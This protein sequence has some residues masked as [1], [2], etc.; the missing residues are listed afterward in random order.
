MSNYVQTTFFAPK[1]A[2]LSGNP[3]KIIRGA[4]VDPELAAIAASIATKYD[5]TLIASAPV[6]F[7]SGTAPLPAI[8][9]GASTTT[10]L[11][12]AGTNVLGFTAAGTAAG[13][14]NAAG[15]WSIAGPAASVPSLAISSSVNAATNAFSVTSGF[16]SIQASPLALFKSTATNG[17]ATIALV[18]NNGTLGTNGLYIFHNGADG[19]G[20]FVL[21]DVSSMRFT[22]SG[23]IN[24]MTIASTGAISIGSPSSGNTLTL[25]QHSGGDGLLV[26]QVATSGAGIANVSASGVESSLLIAQTGAIT[27]KIYNPASSSDLRFNNGTSDVVTLAGNTII[28]PNGAIQAGSTST[29]VA[30]AGD[31]SAVRNSSTNSGVVYLGSSGT[32]FIYFDGTN[33]N[34]PGANVIVNGTTVVSDRRL[35]TNIEPISGALDIVRQLEG[36]NFEYIDGGAKGTGL[37]AQD[38]QK[39]MPMAVVE[40][41]PNHITGDDTKFLSVAYSN[42]VGLLVNAVKELDARLTVKGI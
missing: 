2:L 42:L 3:L 17:S 23:S 16:G 12:S 22:V 38:V 5:S 26:N 41:A 21:D 31:I 10:G 20:N 15:T 37:I 32:K 27:W 36:V 14:I 19:T 11:Y 24:A 7:V 13:S 28:V 34:L 30:A 4:D 39:V 29:G 9:F 25:T 40:Y 35:K 1:D 18:G 6:G 8:Y 33:Y